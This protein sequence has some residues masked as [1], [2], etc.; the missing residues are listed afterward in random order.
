[1]LLGVWLPLL[2]APPPR[3]RSSPPPVVLR[4]EPSSVIGASPSMRVTGEPADAEPAERPL[5][6]ARDPGRRVAE[7][8]ALRMPAAAVMAA[9]RLGG[10]PDGALDGDEGVLPE[11]DR[12]EPPVERMS[13]CRLPV[14]ASPCGAAAAPP[15]AAAA[16]AAACAA[17]GTGEP[18]PPP[19]C[20]PLPPPVAPDAPPASPSL[21]SLLCFATGSGGRSIHCRCL[22]P[23]ATA[24]L[25]SARSGGL[26]GNLVFLTCPSMSLM[27]AQQVGQVS[28]L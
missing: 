11:G 28:M 8:R 1:M 22:S 14:H 21:S 12:G 13:P 26:H 20:L 25:S 6:E 9:A 27:N 3:L 4:G 2:A 23:A 17:C 10:L 19:W 5:T 15:D 18:P 16:A 7:P 24:S